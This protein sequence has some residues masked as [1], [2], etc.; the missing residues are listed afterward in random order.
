MA[1][2]N[3]DFTVDECGMD[4][5]PAALHFATPF[6]VEYHVYFHSFLFL[7]LFLPIFMYRN[8]FLHSSL[9]RIYPLRVSW[10]SACK[11]SCFC[12]KFLFPPLLSN[13]IYVSLCPYF[14]G[15]H[16][17]SSNQHVTILTFVLPNVHCFVY[18]TAGPTTITMLLRLRVFVNYMQLTKKT[19]TPKFY[20][21]LTAT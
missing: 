20:L 2:G 6:R 21:F 7:S 4:A 9:Y 18:S 14:C 17:Y 12:I 8:W 5:S 13:P 15:T 3:S 11:L 16:L 1:A 19:N 10:G